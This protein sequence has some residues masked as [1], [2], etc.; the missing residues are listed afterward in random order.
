MKLKSLLLAMTLGL[1]ALPAFAEETS[2]ASVQNST[3][4]FSFGVP[5]P[6]PLPTVGIGYRTQKDNIGL[7]FN[8]SG[9]WFGNVVCV[10][11]KARVL[12][13]PNPSLDSEV[14]VGVGAAAHSLHS[15]SKHRETEFRIS[16]T[17]T[18][19][20]QYTGDHGGTR[21]IAADLSWVNLSKK[22]SHESRLPLLT[23]NYGIGF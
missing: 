6:L 23:L 8:I 5:V 12:Y 20:K 4:Y 17:I 3:G 9:L 15:L 13:F 19:G 1:S 10:A 16:P 22:D 21:M 7:D 18:L 11:E 14:F 2:S